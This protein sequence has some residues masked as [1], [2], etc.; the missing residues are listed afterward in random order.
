MMSHDP[1]AAGVLLS[2]NEGLE[3]GYGVEP[4]EALLGKC[5]LIPFPVVLRSYVEFLPGSEKD[6]QA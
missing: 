4:R 2:D 6:L 3:E 1:L 5:D